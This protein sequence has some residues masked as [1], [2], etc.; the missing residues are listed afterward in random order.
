MSGIITIE[1]EVP[2][3]HTLY[4]RLYLREICLDNVVHHDEIEAHYLAWETVRKQ[5]N[6]FFENGT[7]FEGYLI[8]RCP[9]AE[10]ALEAILEINQ[11]ILDAIA[12]LY[13]FE[14]GFHSRLMK[15]LTREASDPQAIHIWSTYLGAALGKLRAQMARDVPAQLFRTRTYQ[16]VK[17]LPPMTYYEEGA[18]VLQKYAIGTANGSG[19]SKLIVL[20]QM[21]NP[22]QQ[23]AWLVAGVIGEFGH[24]LV[25]TVLDHLL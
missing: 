9:T 25:R 1:S 13:R 5:I 12:R 7:G 16:I 2:F 19:K 3:G 18:D 14:Y 11:N 20:P 17:T 6:P 4:G 23:D 15:T 21:L 10:S 24:P 8:S 22:S